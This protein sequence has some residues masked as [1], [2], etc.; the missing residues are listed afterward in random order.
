MKVRT[1]LFLPLLLA[2]L[3]VPIHL[4]AQA[5]P[6]LSAPNTNYSRP[7]KSG[8]FS[9]AGNWIKSACRAS[10]IGGGRANS[11]LYAADAAVVGGGIRNNAIAD[12]SMI[13]GGAY[14]YAG[15]LGTVGGGALNFAGT[16][17]FVGGGY[18]NIADGLNAVA[19]G[20]WSNTVSGA[21][22]TVPGGT[23]NK[24]TNIGAFVWSGFLNSNIETV[25]TN[26]NSFTVR[27]PGG[28]R[29][30]TSAS[31]DSSTVTTNTPGNLG[32]VLLPNATTWATLSDSN[33][34]TKITPINPREILA[35]L[36]SLPLAEWEYKADPAGRRYLGPM[37]QDFH[38]AFGLGADD[39]TISTLDSD[40]VLY[41]AIQGLLEEIKT[42]DEQHVKDLGE[43]DQRISE[44]KDRLQDFEN[45]LNSLPPAP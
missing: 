5:L 27:A 1:S 16:H 43:R 8:V 13:G 15:Y 2:V 22:S 21:Y 17:G 19:V 23:F 12:Y 3:A 9:G 37:A 18:A 36:S 38:A 30:I 28:V 41:A 20:G 35:K 26:D 40:G 33:A 34:K 4:H 29:F 6:P 44:L 39:K 45:R 42:R 31:A 14:N 7:L 24:A 32:V 10:F 11:I 25:S